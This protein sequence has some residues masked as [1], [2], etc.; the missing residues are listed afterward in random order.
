VTAVW[1]HPPPSRSRDAR[2]RSVATRWPRSGAHWPPPRRR[3]HLA[4]PGARDWDPSA[5][6]APAQARGGARRAL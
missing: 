5:R 6:C 1:R 2:L 4:E 3:D